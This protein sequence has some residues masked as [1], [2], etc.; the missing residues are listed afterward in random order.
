[1]Q[2]EQLGYPIGETADSS[3]FSGTVLVTSDKE[4]VLTL[5]AYGHANLADNRLNK[6]DTRFG[7]ASGCKLFTAIAVCQ[8]VE[9]GKLSFTDKA[10]D[11]LQETGLTFPMFSPGITVHQLLTHSSG[12][13]DYFDEEIME[14]FAEL[15]KELPM[16]TLRSLQDFLPLFRELPMKFAPG[17]R[18]HYNNAGYI[19]LGLLVEA[20]SGMAF[21]DYVEQYIFRPCGMKHSGYYALD[22]LP[23]NTAMGYIEHGDGT[24]TTNIYS[25][26][27]KGGA[28]GGAFVTVTDM[29]LLWDGLLN[30]RLLNSETTALLLTPHIQEDKEEYYGYGVW[31]T[32]QDGEIFK[33]HLM[34]SDPG[35]S[36]RSAF[37][38]ASGVTFAALCN[39][40]R[41][42]YR[43]MQAVES[44]LP[45]PVTP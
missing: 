13:P 21:H 41:G 9:Q 26:P 11:V 18:F 30:H 22:D 19:M 10:L 40:S 3:G 7:I 38:P 24:L 5:E 6:P 14:D 8:L 15:W 36:F 27:V 32:L 45:R 33:Y 37:Y 42:A 29:Q 39:R 12:I 2:F 25:I 1:M 44:C 20:V 35:V 34:G 31:I 28:D 23:A 4:Q 43:M 16:Y 17:D